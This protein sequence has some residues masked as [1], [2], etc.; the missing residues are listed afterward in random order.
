MGGYW[1][2][3]H[4][5]PTVS[6]GETYTNNIISNVSHVDPMVTIGLTW[7]IAQTKG[8]PASIL[9]RSI[10]YLLVSQS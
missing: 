3:I 2:V 5:T 1:A 4:T 10:K 9:Y 8:N 7:E 6:S